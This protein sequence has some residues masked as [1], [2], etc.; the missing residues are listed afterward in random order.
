[1]FG[2]MDKTPQTYWVYI[3]QCTDGSFYCGIALDVAARLEQ[4]NT[5]KLGARYTK[6]RRPVSLVYQA[7]CGTRSEALKEEIRIKRLSRV[8][9][10]SLVETNDTCTVA[11]V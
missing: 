4:H 10:Q 11:D 5:S 8:E 7:E 3:V 1:M 6:S 9:K 2:G